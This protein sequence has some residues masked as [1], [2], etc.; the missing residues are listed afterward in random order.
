MPRLD[1]APDAS[2]S[3]AVDGDAASVVKAVVASGCSCFVSDSS[4]LPLFCC[5]FVKRVGDMV[6][7]TL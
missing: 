3:N 7:G 1:A 6:A 5:L 2:L 4:S